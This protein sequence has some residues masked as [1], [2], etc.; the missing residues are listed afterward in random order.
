MTVNFKFQ[1]F[2][3]TGNFSL[4][5]SAGE[6]LTDNFINGYKNLDMKLITWGGPPQIKIVQRIR[7]RFPCIGLLWA[8][9]EPQS[10]QHFHSRH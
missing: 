4:F 6:R 5:A 1:N 10:P 2:E 3:N 8:L 7:L 9:K